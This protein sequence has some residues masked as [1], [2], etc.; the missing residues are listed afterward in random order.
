MVGR[1][2]AAE[3]EES[4]PFLHVVT[5]AISTSQGHFLKHGLLH[6]PNAYLDK[7]ARTEF[8]IA[9]WSLCHGGLPQLIGR[10]LMRSILIVF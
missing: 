6:N 3:W 7:M 4:S 9:F 5:K 10:P 8:L 1:V 2:F